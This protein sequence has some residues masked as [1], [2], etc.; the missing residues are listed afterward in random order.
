MEEGWD[1]ATIGGFVWFSVSSM[2]SCEIDPYFALMVLLLRRRKA[3]WLYKYA[4][5]F[6]R[7]SSKH[8]TQPFN[9]LQVF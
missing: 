2:L 6:G 4:G 1:R 8:V 5:S 7:G 3:L 9:T